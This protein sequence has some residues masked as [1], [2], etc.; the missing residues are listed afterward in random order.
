[1][2]AKVTQNLERHKEKATMT[3][4]FLALLII[5]AIATSA[6]VLRAAPDDKEKPAASKQ[7]FFEMRTY[8]SPVGKL[9][10]LNARFRNHTNKLFVKHGMEL[11]GYWTPAD[12]PTA[13]N[14]L[15]YILAY[16]SREAREKAWK[17][18]QDDPEWKKVRAETEKDGKIVEKVEAVFLKPTDYSPIK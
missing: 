16:P 17:A 5:S 10:A 3:K 1:L 7:R 13:E 6:V 8:I 2:G 11:V 18:F 9:D 4:A 15:V 12:G 14:T